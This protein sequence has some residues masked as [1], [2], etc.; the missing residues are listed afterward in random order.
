MI[1]VS[2]KESFLLRNDLRLLIKAA[3][4]TV[5]LAW[6]YKATSATAGLRRIPDLL[7]CAFDRLPDGA[8]SITV[9][10]PAC[11]EEASIS[12]CLTSLMDQDYGDLDILAIN[13]RSK[14]ATGDIMDGLAAQRPARLRVRHIRAL[15]PDWLGKTH[16]MA[17]GARDSISLRNPDWLLFTDADVIFHPQAIRRSLVQATAQEADHFVTVPTALVRSPGEGFMLGFLQVIGLWA[18][19]LWRVE[20][21]GSRDAIGIGAFN[22]IRSSA[23]S[24]LG[25]FDAAPMAILEDLTL[26]RRVKD[27]GLRQR[28]AFAEGYVSIHWAPGALGVVNTM[29]KNLF[30][31]FQFR[32]SLLLIACAG[33]TALCIAPFAGLTFRI[34]RKPSIVAVIAIAILYRTSSRY[35]GIGSW[36][37]VT[38]PLAAGLFLYSLLR[39][40]AVTLL[41]GSVRWRGTFYPIEDLRRKSYRL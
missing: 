15:P 29:T 14:D 1:L 7:D 11:D 13:D 8:P 16:A 30:A 5:A 2:H 23:Y 28:V 3:A 22:L 37:F 38:F 27:L 32:P 20:D 25:G 9:I 41:N 18:T 31:V 24:S 4:W 34:S 17:L 12:A 21:P 26:A 36:N 6:V 39:S 40:M 19:R 33:L 10:V 35:S